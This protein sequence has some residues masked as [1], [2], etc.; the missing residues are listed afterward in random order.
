M[1]IPCMIS[2]AVHVLRMLVAAAAAAAAGSSSRERRGRGWNLL[3][4]HYACGP[5]R[6]TSL[7]A[8]SSFVGIAG[9]AR[10]RGMDWLLSK[11]EKSVAR[12]AQLAV[13]NMHEQMVLLSPPLSICVYYTSLRISVVT[14]VPLLES[15]LLYHVLY[16]SVLTSF[17]HNP[18]H[19]M[20]SLQNNASRISKESESLN[21]R[22]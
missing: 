9:R 22:V 10:T 4:L 6:D 5:Y 18:S 1:D 2:R 3:F 12:N 19:Y 11:R 15:S 13:K 20:L 7:I 8:S 16:Y 14:C 17:F 21:W